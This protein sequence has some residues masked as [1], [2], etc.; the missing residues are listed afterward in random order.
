LKS[1]APTMGTLILERPASP[2]HVWIDGERLAGESTTVAC[3]R[4]EIRVG[5]HGRAHAIDV[6]CGGDVRVAR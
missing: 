3:G 1:A 6:P 2:G 5:V 4:H